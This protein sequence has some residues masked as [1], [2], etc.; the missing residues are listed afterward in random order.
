MI[1]NFEN[2]SLLRQKKLLLNNINWQINTGE[3]W[4]LLGLNGAGKTLLLQLLSGNLWPSQGKLTVLGETFGETAIPDL[5]KRIGFVS[6]SLHTKIY[7]NDLA[8]EIVLSGKFASIGIYQ[9]YTTEDLATAKEWLITIGSDTLIGKPYQVLSQGEKQA[10][11]I[12]RALMSNPEL[13]ILDEACNGLD[14][15]AREDLLN[16]ITLLKQTPSAPTILFVTHHTE[17]I[18]PFI[19][20]ILMIKEG[21]IFAQ[22]PRENL[23]DP[24][25]LTDFYDREITIQHLDDDRLLVYPKN[26]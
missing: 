13:L 17:E 19:S 12:A 14:L 22:G 2:V 15:F 25:V 21:K 16:R 5:V 6:N 11:L 1:L 4:A 26:I 9:E 8:E 18:L 10:V 7:Q 23:L 20:H 24:R 3:D